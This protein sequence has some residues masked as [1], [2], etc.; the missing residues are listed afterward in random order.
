MFT[1]IALRITKQDF[2]RDAAQKNP[3]KDAQEWDTWTFFSE[4]IIERTSFW[5]TFR[6]LFFGVAIWLCPESELKHTIK[7]YKHAVLTSGEEKEEESQGAA[8]VFDDGLNWS[9]TDFTGVQFHVSHQQSAA[10]SMHR[11]P[12]LRYHNYFFPGSLSIT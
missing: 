10:N 7:I 3:Q 11:S 5:N 9:M 2:I 12:K 4:N 8:D 6:H 1:G